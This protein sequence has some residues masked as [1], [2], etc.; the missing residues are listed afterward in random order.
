MAENQE[1]SIHGIKKNT[2]GHIKEMAQELRAGFELLKKYQKSVTIFG[3]ARSRSGNPHYKDAKDLAYRIAK[4]LNYAVITGGGPGIM[5]AANEGA[6]DA[7][8]DSV[9]IT[10]ELPHEQHTNPHTTDFTNCKY[11]MTRKS[12][13]NFSAEAYVFFPGGYGTFDELFGVLT[14][15]QTGK[16]PKVP[17][18]LF[19]KD[20]WNPFNNFINENVVDVHHTIDP[21]DAKLY[22]ITDNI[23]KALEIIQNAPVSKWWLQMD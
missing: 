16:I 23:D 21:E 7:G 14:L 3:S 13:L 6:K 1:F 15:I 22:T 10:I 2:E 8:G 19:G 9:A 20:F 5:W 17:V 18:I 4:D 12:L 11:F